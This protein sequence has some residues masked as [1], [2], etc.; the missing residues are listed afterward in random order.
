LGV[1]VCACVELSIHRPQHMSVAADDRD[2]PLSAVLRITNTWEAGALVEVRVGA[3]ADGQLFTL[4]FPG[5]QL[6]IDVRSLAH[7][8][9]ENKQISHGSTVLRLRM[10]PIEFL[11]LCYDASKC[12]FLQTKM[13]FSFTLSPPPVLA[14]P[15]LPHISCHEGSWPPTLPPPPIGLPSRPP[16]P[17]PPPAQPPGI[18]PPPQ[19]SPP[20]PRPSPP[21]VR[22]WPTAL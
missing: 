18:P 19:P 13:A 1:C 15:F 17:P 6:V 3:W 9:L 7:A 22:D 8:T 12:G 2:C 10:V 5:Q 20:P 4:T 21:P 11:H 16:T 14:M